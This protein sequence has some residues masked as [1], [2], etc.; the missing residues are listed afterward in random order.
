[1]KISTPFKHNNDLYN[2]KSPLFHKNL[3]LIK[4]PSLKTNNMNFHLLSKSRNKVTDF[5]IM[6][7]LWNDLGV[8]IE[9]QKQFE[10]KRKS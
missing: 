4:I 10:R 1:M 9:Y 8:N 7:S 6:K 5:I 2:I 3:D